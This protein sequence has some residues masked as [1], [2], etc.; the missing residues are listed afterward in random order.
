M[1]QEGINYGLVMNYIFLDFENLQPEEINLVGRED[2]EIWIFLGENQRKISIELVKSLQPLGNQVK[3]IS[4]HGS[5]KNA[6]DFH[7]AFYI[8]E[9]SQKKPDA[10]FHLLSRDSG[11]DPLIAHL[12]DKQIRCY[13]C[14]RVDDILPIRLTKQK[15]ARQ[16]VSKEVDYHNATTSQLAQTFKKFF[17]SKTNRP[18]SITALEN[19]CRNIYGCQLDGEKIKRLIQSLQTTDYIVVGE[20]N[21]VTYPNLE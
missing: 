16:G 17:Q 4:M 10:F 19:V 15:Q 13:R 12:R 2:F 9:V 20:N 3:Y 7:I 5:G 8:G 18:K 14:E 1:S 6:L 11:F 21:K